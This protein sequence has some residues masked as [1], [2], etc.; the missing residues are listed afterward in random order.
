MRNNQPV[1]QREVEVPEGVK[2]VSTTDPQGRITHCNAAF[3][4]I[5][6]YDYSELLGQPHNIVRHPDVPEQAFKDLWATVGRGRPWS[7]VVKN[8]C[9]NGDHY[10]V[11]AHVT[12]VRREGR[13]IGYISV[14]ERPSR[15]QITA[16]E[17][18]Y[19]QLGKDDCPWRLHAGGL[20][21][22]GWRDWPQTVFRLSL[23]Q[24]LGIALA[25]WLG[26]LAAG[27]WALLAP[28]LDAALLA[29]GALAVWAWFRHSIER[30]L[31]HCIDMTAQIAACNLQGDIDYDMR[32]PVG[33]LMRNVRLLNLNMQAIVADVRAEVGAIADSAQEIA[34]GS[35]DLAMRT[36]Q[37][38]AG[39]ERTASSMEQITSVVA[40]T[41]ATANQV[42]LNGEAARGTAVQGGQ[43]VQALVGTMRSIDEASGRVAEVIR[44]IEGIAFQTNLLALNAAVEAARAG[45]Q[46]KGFAVVAGEVR[47]LAQRCTTAAQEIRSL[48]GHST[49]RVAD[50]ARHV[51]SAHS[52]M[53]EVVAAVAE[54]S[55]RMRD[56]S[57]AA[58]EQAAGVHELNR[59]ISEI[60]QGTQQ[61]AALAEQTA[62]ACDWLQS[63]AG[64]LQRAV[65]I[66]R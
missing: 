38:S 52:I 45:E 51:E 64:T 17:A 56:I 55:S 31:A 60:E 40:Q 30:K 23:S 62:A 8:R 9:K 10:W 57:Q 54:V 42:G 24:R 44:V 37:Q 35:Q 46:G 50:G 28:A 19:A 13:N 63:R 3:V 16:A 61:N 41:A 21:R 22:K 65:A 36:E 26:L 29:G 66:F 47:A 27:H 5:C 25:G 18:L 33:Q 15:A 48:I 58:D 32:H 11:L 39:V 12:P 59:A 53:A 6:G 20:R 4:A 43:S 14:R 34:R 49:A 2:L 1:T 7:G